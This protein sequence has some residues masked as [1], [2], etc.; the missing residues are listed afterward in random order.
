[1]MTLALTA[2]LRL[3]LGQTV[4]LACCTDPAIP[5]SCWPVSDPADLTDCDPADLLSWCILEDT[6]FVASCTEAHVLCC[7]DAGTCSAHAPGS[8]CKGVMVLQ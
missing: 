5:S 4:G 6:G 3:L 2:V 7:D 1:M 8:A